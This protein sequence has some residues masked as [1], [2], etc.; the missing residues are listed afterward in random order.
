MAG[1]ALHVDDIRV[2]VVDDEEDM[3]TLVRATIELADEGLSV[4]GEAVDGDDAVRKWH[5]E[6]PDVIVLDERM[7]VATG[8]EAARRILAEDPNQPVVMLTA[9]PDRRVQLAAG[10]LGVRAC[11]SKDDIR[12]LA[13]LLRTICRP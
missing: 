10:R 6:R 9:Y 5:D 2:L 4:T 8:L 12:V 1:A 11:M 7:P 13:P 3:R